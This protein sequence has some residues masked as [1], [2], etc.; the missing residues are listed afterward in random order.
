MNLKV[1]NR[2]IKAEDVANLV[3]SNTDIVVSMC[4]SEPQYTLSHLHLAA[5]RVRNVNVFS[6]LTM[7]SYDFFSKPEME[8]HFMLCSWFMGHQQERPSK[9]VSKL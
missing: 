3:K 4:A 9:E 1:A 6:C 7:K 5:S 2:I 8:D